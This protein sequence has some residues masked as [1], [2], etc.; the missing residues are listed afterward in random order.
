MSDTGV[1]TSS[2][3]PS[4]VGTSDERFKPLTN[5]RISHPCATLLTD[6]RLGFEAEDMSSV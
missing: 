6:P 5:V 3:V 4:R 1:H 2:V